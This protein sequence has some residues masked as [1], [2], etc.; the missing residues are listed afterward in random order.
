MGE[1]A[2]KA[3]IVEFNDKVSQNEA[4]SVMASHMRSK[5]KARKRGA[6]SGAVGAILGHVTEERYDRALKEL[7]EYLNSKPEYPEFKNRSE[8]YIQYAGDLVQA[9]RAKRGFPGWNALNI[10]KQ[11]DLFDKAILHFDDLK[12]TLEKVEVI[13][14]EVRI[15]DVKST[16]WVIQAFVYAVSLLLIVAILKELTGGLM[17]SG[18]ILFDH[19]MGQ[20]VDLI[21]DKL[22]L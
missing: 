19:S 18:Q 4:G 11:Q 7:T 10:S 13:E 6:N 8:R 9:I 5:A 20:L 12:A 14:R 1:P 22:K 3:E 21:F 16:V 17:E 15:E 2:E